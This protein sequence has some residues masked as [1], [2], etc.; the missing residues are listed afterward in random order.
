MGY[1]QA[2]GR[3]RRAI[4]KVAATGTAPA[5]IVR[6]VFGDEDGRA[7]T[8]PRA[9]CGPWARQTGRAAQSLLTD[10]NSGPS[11]QVQPVPGTDISKDHSIA[12][13]WGG[14]ACY[15]IDHFGHF[16]G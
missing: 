3:L 1:A 16:A 9:C 6:E 2:K 14:C 4:A 5:A 7:R 15:G 11:G 13:T 12:S 10:T 8:W